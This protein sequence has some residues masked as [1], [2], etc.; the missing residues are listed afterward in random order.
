MSKMFLRHFTFQNFKSM[1]QNTCMS[2]ELLTAS[3][4]KDGPAPC[5]SGLHCPFTYETMMRF[6]MTILGETGSSNPK[7]LCPLPFCARARVPAHTSLT[8]TFF[9]TRL[10][11]PEIW[12]YWSKWPKKREKNLNQWLRCYRLLPK[13][14]TCQTKEQN[15]R[16]D[17]NKRLPTSQPCR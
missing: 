10:W 6:S 14:L 17:S 11:W 12:K 1:F 4:R 5:S 15:N 8:F 9:F 2:L 3:L 7:E 13:M 16:P